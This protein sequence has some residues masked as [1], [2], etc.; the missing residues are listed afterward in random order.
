MYLQ[1]TKH[2]EC[3]TVGLQLHDVREGEDWEVLKMT[4]DNLSFLSVCSPEKDCWC[5]LEKD[6]WLSFLAYSL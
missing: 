3:Y 5:S 2:I 1:N 4:L 6:C